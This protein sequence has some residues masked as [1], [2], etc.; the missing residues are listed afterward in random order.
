[1]GGQIGTHIALKED[2][3]CKKLVLIAPA[4]FETFSKQEE[5]WFKLV[6][7]PAII[8]ATPEAQIVNNFHLN[9]HAFPDD[10]QFMI[11]DRM[12]MLDTDA[13]DAYCKMIPKCVAGMLEEPVYDQLDKLSM[14]TLIIFGEEDLLIPNRIL[15]SNLTT[16]EIAKAGHDRISKSTLYMIP[17]AGHF[18][19]WEQAAMTNEL[20]VDFLGQAQK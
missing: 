19:Q 5:Q 14:P 2:S 15:H 12:E 17:S 9:F 18:V 10:A 11:N 7:T 13:Y 3:R 20:I 16:E 4:G 1:M 8:K 6:F